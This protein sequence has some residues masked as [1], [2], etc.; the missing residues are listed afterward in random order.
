MKRLIVLA[1]LALLAGLTDAPAHAQS[2]RIYTTPE[3]VADPSACPADVACEPD[4][5]GAPASPPDARVWSVRTRG[6]PPEERPAPAAPIAIIADVDVDPAEY[7]GRSERDDRP[8]PPRLRRD[9]N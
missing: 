5:E 2:T 1:V 4:L 9:E 3:P 6:A 8:R 7:D